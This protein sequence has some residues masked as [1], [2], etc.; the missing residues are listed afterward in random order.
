[1]STI[2]EPA[3]DAP[4]AERVAFGARE[5]D[6]IERGWYRQ[7]DLNCLN[8]AHVGFCIAGQ[9]FGDFEYCEDELGW[10]DEATVARGLDLHFG[11]DSLNGTYGELDQLWKNE[12]TNRFN[13]EK[14]NV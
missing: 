4:A 13:A 9:L 2:T 1:M 7:I 12:I 14:D 11:G 10:S 8:M 6:R 3:I 5:M